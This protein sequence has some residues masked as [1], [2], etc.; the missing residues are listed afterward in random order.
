MKLPRLLHMVLAAALAAFAL[1]AHA[2]SKKDTAPADLYVS[3]TI[4]S[5]I[6]DT[7]RHDDV[8]EVF[9][10]RVFE[11]FRAAGYKGKIVQDNDA[12]P[13]GDQR[14]LELYVMEWRN[15]RVGG[16]TCTFTAELEREG[17]KAVR[18]GV[19]TTSSLRNGGGS[20]ASA[21]AFED[22]AEDALRDLYKKLQKQNLLVTPASESKT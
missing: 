15:D 21:N 16:I 8:A 12:K 3:I 14:R 2:A 19:F 22:S 18:L 11:S 10:G 6:G 4:P 1:T 9:M 7:W 17:V 5:L 13:K 20:I